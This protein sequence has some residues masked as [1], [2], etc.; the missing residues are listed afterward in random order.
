MAMCQ[1]KKNIYIYKNIEIFSTIG[2]V[3]S[4]TVTNI[5]SVHTVCITRCF[6]FSEP[7]SVFL[8]WNYWVHG[9]RGGASWRPW[10]WLRKLNTFVKHFTLQSSKQKYSNPPL[11]GHSLERPPKLMWPKL[12]L[13][14]LGM[15]L[16]LL[17]GKGRFSDVAT[18]SCQIGWCY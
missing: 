7:S 13:L 16:L 5:S 9:T 6:L 4:S 8:L 3:A 12:L 17:L 18:F 15:H 14:L 11:S 10:P 1:L 2:H